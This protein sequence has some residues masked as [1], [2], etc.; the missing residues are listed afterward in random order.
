[1]G[2]GKGLNIPRKREATWEDGINGDKKVSAPCC[3]PDP[4]NFTWICVL[5]YNMSV[6]PLPRNIPKQAFCSLV[7]YNMEDGAM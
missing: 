2:N 7:F 1:M 4:R 5:L 3:H 6:F